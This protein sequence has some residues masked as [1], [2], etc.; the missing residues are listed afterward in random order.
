MYIN[1]TIFILFFKVGVGW[2]DP[3]ELVIGRIK[4]ATIVSAK[5]FSFDNF[6]FA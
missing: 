2:H 6:F 4:V 1:T 3:F 5:K